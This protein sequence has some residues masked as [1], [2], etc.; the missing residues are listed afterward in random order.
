MFRKKEYSIPSTTGNSSAKNWKRT[1]KY[2]IFLATHFIKLI[3]QNI[4]KKIYHKVNAL[5]LLLLVKLIIIHISQYFDSKNTRLLKPQ[6]NELFV[7]C[8]DIT[9]I[10][11]NHYSFET[12]LQTLKISFMKT[13]IIASWIWKVVKTAAP[14]LFKL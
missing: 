4:T 1:N 9:I 3:P 2:K 11:V 13:F 14:L 6:K 8:F 12:V 7:F 10:I 5:K